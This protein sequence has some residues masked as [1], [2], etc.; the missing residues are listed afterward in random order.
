MQTCIPKMKSRLFSLNSELPRILPFR[1]IHLLCLVSHRLF[2]LAFISAITAMLVRSLQGKWKTA[3]ILRCRVKVS[4]CSG[5]LAHCFLCASLQ[6]WYILYCT[7]HIGAMGIK[8]PKMSIKLV[9]GF[10]KGY[11][12]KM[13]TTENCCN[14]SETSMHIGIWF[15]TV[16]CREKSFMWESHIHFLKCL[17][18]L[19]PSPQVNE[20][21]LA[22][23]NSP[24]GHN[25][26]KKD[27]LFRCQTS[28]CLSAE[29]CTFA[30][31]GVVGPEVTWI[32]CGDFFFLFRFL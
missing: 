5:S 21:Q 6:C 7:V 18:R 3:V 31:V 30:N 28:P 29:E 12:K 17:I 8:V 25:G 4:T 23:L 1:H 14:I 19:N 15:Y 32:A 16:F 2:I 26:N 27:W 22:Q 13:E 9:G 20:E 11:L 10:E 24:K